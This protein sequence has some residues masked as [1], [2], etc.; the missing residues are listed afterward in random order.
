M[1]ETLLKLYVMAIAGDVRTPTPHL[2]RPARM[3]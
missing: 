3:R 1:L 2:F